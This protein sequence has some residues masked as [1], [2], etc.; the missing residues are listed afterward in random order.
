M[1]AD[2]EIAGRNLDVEVVEDS[3]GCWIGKILRNNLK[4]YGNMNWMVSVL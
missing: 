2:K 3:M 1:I 4:E